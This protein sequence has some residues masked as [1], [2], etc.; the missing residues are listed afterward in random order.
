MEFRMK[1]TTDAPKIAEI[2]NRVISD[3][4]RQKFDQ[5]MGDDKLPENPAYFLSLIHI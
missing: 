5:L 3:E 2:D 1:E 4:A